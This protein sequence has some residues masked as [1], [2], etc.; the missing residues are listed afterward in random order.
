MVVQQH[1]GEPLHYEKCKK[2][3][4]ADEIPWRPPAM[5]SGN[6]RWPLIPGWGT[7]DRKEMPGKQKAHQCWF[8]VDSITRRIFDAKKK[9]TGTLLAEGDEDGPCNAQDLEPGFFAL[10]RSSRRN[11]RRGGSLRYPDSRRRWMGEIDVTSWPCPRVY[12]RIYYT[13]LDTAASAASMDH[14]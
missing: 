13:G 9:D 8:V 3:V 2:K 5:M 1:R 7:P 6:A 4:V 11:R 14:I 10:L 12:A